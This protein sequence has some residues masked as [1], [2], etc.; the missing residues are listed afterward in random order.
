V[1]TVAHDFGEKIG[2]GAHL[3]ALRRTATDRFNISQAIT[4]EQ[5]GAMDTLSI[6]RILISPHDAAPAGVV[7]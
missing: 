7:L 5:L 2:C 1:R 4:L 3:S 6:R